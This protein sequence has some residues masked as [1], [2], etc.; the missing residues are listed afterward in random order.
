MFEMIAILI[1][2][3]LLHIVYMY[4]ILSLSPKYVQLKYYSNFKI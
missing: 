2:I 3:N 4:Q 1:T